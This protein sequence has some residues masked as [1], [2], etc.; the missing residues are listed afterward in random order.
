MKNFLNRLR[1]TFSGFMQGRYGFDELNK[2]LYIAGLILYL[3]VIIFPRLVFLSFFAVFGIAWAFMRCMSKNFI[4]RQAERA[5][6]LKIKNKIDKKLNFY[7]NAWKAR[8]THKYFKCEKCKA[9]LKVPK[10]KGKIQV[11]C[12]KCSHKMIKKT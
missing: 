12:P 10:G 5:A 9:S 8:K 4:K 6:F 7:K 11:T 3:V 2:F 1:Y